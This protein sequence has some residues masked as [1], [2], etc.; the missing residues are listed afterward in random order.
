MSF[1]GKH[2]EEFPEKLSRTSGYLILY[3]NQNKTIFKL[4][5]SPT[6]KK[7]DYK[8]GLLYWN[9]FRTD[10]MKKDKEHFTKLFNNKYEKIYYRKYIVYKMK[11]EDFDIDDP[12]CDDGP[13]CDLYQYYEEINTIKNRE[14]EEIDEIEIA[15]NKL[16]QLLHNK[17][18][19]ENKKLFDKFDNMKKS[20]LSIKI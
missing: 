8:Y 1:Q 11:A 2:S 9:H 17:Q 20:I 10:N 13:L 15:K 14:D 7:K 18:K 5:Y 3:H 19:E 12:S 6:L 16:F 4:A